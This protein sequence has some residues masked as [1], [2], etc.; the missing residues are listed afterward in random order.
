MGLI[1]LEIKLHASYSLNAPTYMSFYL[2]L[3]WLAS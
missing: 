2:P 1:N 3:R